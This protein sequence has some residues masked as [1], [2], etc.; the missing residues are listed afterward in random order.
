[1]FEL[2]SCAE[3]GAQRNYEDLVWG[4]LKDGNSTPRPHFNMPRALDLPLTMWLTGLVMPFVVN[5]ARSR[6][7][8]SRNIL[9]TSWKWSW[10]AEVKSWHVLLGFRV[11]ELFKTLLLLLGKGTTHQYFETTDT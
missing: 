11:T 9:N 7:R 8:V 3:Y 2:T 10:A 5:S 4:I 6:C 1:M